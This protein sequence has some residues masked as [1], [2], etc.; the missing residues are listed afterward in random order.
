MKE[1]IKDFYLNLMTSPTMRQNP[2]LRRIQFLYIEMKDSPKMSNLIKRKN[3]EFLVYLRSKK[4]YKE[5]RLDELQE[6]ILDLFD[7]IYDDFTPLQQ[8]LEN[9]LN[10]DTFKMPERAQLLILRFSFGNFLMILLVFLII[11]V[12]VIRKNVK[13]NIMNFL[14]LPVIYFGILAIKELYA[15][16]R[17]K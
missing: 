17:D 15:N 1:Y 5:I 3:I 2:K 13:E 8:P 11:A 12:F 6:T 10:N 4:S 7:D 9:Y 16:Y 14:W